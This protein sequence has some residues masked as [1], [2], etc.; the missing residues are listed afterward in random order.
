[1]HPVTSGVSAVARPEG[2]A[3]RDSALPAAI[4][5]RHVDDTP[6][7]AA[8]RPHWN[9]LLRSSAADSPFLTW[10]WLYAWWTHLAGSSRLDILTLYSGGTLVAIAPLRLSSGL[11]PTVEFLGTGE[12]GSDYL[13]VIV[14]RG[15]ETT[16]LPALAEALA[17]GSR[18]LQLDH[19]APLSGAAVVAG[20]LGTR[21]WTRH[22]TPGGSC[23]VISLN[24]HTWDSYLG[25]L[26][27][28]HR[29][30]VRRRLRELERRP[31]W[32]FER[33]SSELARD[34][35][36]AALV[37]FHGGRWGEEG[38]TAFTTP[39]LR[40]FHADATSRALAAGWLRMYVLRIDGAPAAVMY[41]F[42]YGDRFYFYQHGYDARYADCSLGLTMMALCIRA[43]IDEGAREFD[44][45][46][47]LE[48]YKRL[49]AR[50]TV[51][52]ERI[53]LFPPDAGG[54][55]RRLTFGATAQLR[56]LARGLVGA[57]FRRPERNAGHGR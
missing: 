48:P 42:A 22:V 43:A 50:D 1:M 51:A 28:S 4:A 16:C 18:T 8:L 25:S 45:L 33:V 52:L 36:L 44:M 40:A 15:W 55:V 17:G 19:V 31:D 34:E 38:S 23:P 37:G 35:A 57:A 13:D 29:A 2:R 9:E 12:A 11:L 53:H 46:W 6:A 56:R 27:S 39:V 20:A 30:N 14:R 21:G 47:G 26:G 54:M 3:L 41:G 49:W 7:F 32:Q 24:D 5:I 10:E